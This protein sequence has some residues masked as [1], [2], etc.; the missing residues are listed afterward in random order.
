WYRYPSGFDYFSGRDGIRLEKS[1]SGGEITVV[2]DYDNSI[3]YTDYILSELT[4]GLRSAGGYSWLLYFS[5]HGEE[6]YDLESEMRFGRN[7]SRISKYMLDVPVI[8]WMSDEYR[9][10]GEAGAF[11]EYADRPYELDGMIHTVIDLAG[12]DTPLLDRTKSL[13]SEFYRMPARVL[14]NPRKMTYLSV[15]PED[16]ANPR[17]SEEERRRSEAAASNSPRN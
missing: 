5:D 6:V 1:M 3:R 13:V 2:N 17:T 8:L 9:K 10:K 7:P 11:K 14:F 15:M 16:L 4:E 12:I